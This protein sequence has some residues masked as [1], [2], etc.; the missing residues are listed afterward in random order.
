MK[1][2][3]EPQDP[4]SAAAYSLRREHVLARLDP[5]LQNAILE[6]REGRPLPR[7]LY[8]R[9][10]EGGEVV[11]VIAKLRRPGEKVEGLNVSQQIGRIVTGSV[12]VED[13][14]KVRR[15]RN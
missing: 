2:S 11:D 6:H 1:M 14:V 13:I 8:G 4:D 9:K 5:E 3:N 12:A 10:G 15:H 7:Y